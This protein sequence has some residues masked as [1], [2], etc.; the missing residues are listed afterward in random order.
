MPGLRPDVVAYDDALTALPIVARA[1][2][3]MI[4]NFSGRSKR[5]SPSV[6]C[7]DRQR[8]RGTLAVALV[9]GISSSTHALHADTRRHGHAD[10][11]TV[12]TCAAFG[13]ASRS[14]RCDAQARNLELDT[15]TYNG[16]DTLSTGQ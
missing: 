9:P 15:P 3:N 2:I 4:S 1:T 5:G 11:L 6:R 10:A 12:N 13:E 7:A 8:V 14:A 16:K